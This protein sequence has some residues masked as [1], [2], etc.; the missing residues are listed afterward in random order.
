MNGSISKV[1]KTYKLSENYFILG[2][3][4]TTE[5]SKRQ[6]SFERCSNHCN[7]KPPFPGVL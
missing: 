6:F 1:L 2:T 7:S 5:A 3:C 4:S